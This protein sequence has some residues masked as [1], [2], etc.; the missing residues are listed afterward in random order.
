MLSDCKKTLQEKK[1][2]RSILTELITL[3]KRI[4]EMYKANERIKDKEIDNKY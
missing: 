4:T 2:L 1:E 3:K